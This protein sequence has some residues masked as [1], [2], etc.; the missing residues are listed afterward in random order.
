MTIFCQAD[1]DLEIQDIY[2]LN[3]KK[4]KADNKIS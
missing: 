1:E 4:A 3:L 2:L